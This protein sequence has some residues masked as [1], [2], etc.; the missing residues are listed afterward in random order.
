MKRIRE[1]FVNR[2]QAIEP[3]LASSADAHLE[4]KDKRVFL[5]HSL[6][7]FTDEYKHELEEILDGVDFDVLRSLV[8]ES[9]GRSGF[10][11]E[12][13][14]FLNKDRVLLIC[15]NRFSDYGDKS[16][17][18]P[19]DEGIRTVPL[20]TLGEYSYKANLVH[21]YATNID[22]FKRS[23]ES[24]GLVKED[25]RDKLEMP[26]MKLLILDTLVRAEIKAS[27]K[28]ECRLTVEGNHYF[29]EQ[30]KAG[31]EQPD[32]SGNVLYKLFNEAVAEKRAQELTQKYL[33][34]ETDFTD[35][36]DVEKLYQ[37]WNRLGDRKVLVSLVNMMIEKLSDTV[38]LPQETVW[39]AF[40]RG[41][42]EGEELGNFADLFA[43]I[44]SRDFLF[45][46]AHC[47]NNDEA[48]K[49]ID[50]MAISEGA[51]RKRLDLNKAFLDTDHAGAYL[52][53]VFPL[54]KDKPPKTKGSA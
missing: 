33:K 6:T 32:V 17:D 43:E 10:N 1:M 40:V 8:L 42:E 36:A 27:S 16:L 23:K 37:M 29:V 7:I 25:M 14:N 38:G 21:I 35:K 53:D 47:D 34:R 44:F 46:L 49:L 4:Q 9:C 15:G 13:V 50:E 45:R 12:N 54:Y 2:G 11:P 41:Q 31:Y 5:E 3:E 30:L 18:N 39:Q 51:V 52:A 22:F 24:G 20:D 26:N 28:Q 19:R 48:L